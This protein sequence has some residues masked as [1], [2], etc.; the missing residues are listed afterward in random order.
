MNIIRMI[1]EYHEHAYAHK[2]HNVGEIEQFLQRHNLPNSQKSH[3]YT[4][5][6]RKNIWQNLTL[7]KK[8]NKT[9]QKNCR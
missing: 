2:F 8:Q 4:N 7:I 6:W 5:I 3:N 1:K 9:K